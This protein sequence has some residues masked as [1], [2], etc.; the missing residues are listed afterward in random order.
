MENTLY[1]VLLVDDEKNILDGL[2]AIIDWNGLGCE[3]LAAVSNG[4]EGLEMIKQYI[5]DIIITDI[6]MKT[7]TGLE[8]LE[9]AVDLIGNTKIIV[10]TGY[11]DFEYAH[12][13][14]HLGVSAF[15][16]KP[17]DFE[18]LTNAIKTAVREIERDRKIKEKLL[19]IKENISETYETESKDNKNY[20]MLKLAESENAFEKIS[21]IFTVVTMDVSEKVLKNM[22]NEIYELF[23]DIMEK[24]YTLLFLTE[25]IDNE[26]TVVLSSKNKN[27]FAYE[28]FY[29][30]IEAV[31]KSF[32]KI[33]SQNVCMGVSTTGDSAKELKIKY[34][35]CKRALEHKLYT[36][37]DITLFYEDIQK[38]SGV[39]ANVPDMDNTVYEKLVSC[40][41]TGNEEGLDNHLNEFEKGAENIT[42]IGE[43][44]N[45]C[46]QT[47]FKIYDLYKSMNE[48]IDNI[49]ARKSI[50]YVIKKSNDRT[51]IVRLVFDV[52]RNVTKKFYDYNNTLFGVTLKKAMAYVSENFNK[53]LT[54]D[55]IAR[56]IGVTPSYVSILFRKGF[57][58][59]Y[60][61]Y[62]TN[63]RI[64]EAKRLLKK[65]D[66]KVYQIAET[67][68]FEDAY[69]F[70]K[71][72]KNVVGISPKEY[73]IQCEKSEIE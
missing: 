8:M 25:T 67:V 66:K 48:N 28:N 22:K 15:I 56:V 52:S 35:E 6:K 17:T 63:I 31:R 46:I 54:R 73:R 18:E 9:Q 7:M 14:I 11:R 5:P 30:K 68:G 3:I 10:M 19:E 45:I 39:S 58:M 61:E 37:G 38:T 60:V 50:E 13:A 44:K 26:V 69:Y 16:L 20:I 29:P 1:K 62:I 55:D 23:D 64:G 27:F 34:L 4:E 51:E 24:Q 53:M 40:I 70:S 12:K 42:D 36:N 2:R 47:I 33:F 43:L 21:D 41:L 59:T 57:D 65:T 71:I 32:E 72:F 49:E